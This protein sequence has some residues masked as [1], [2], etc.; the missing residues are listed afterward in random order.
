M[1][2]IS[3]FSFSGDIFLCIDNISWKFK[4][5]Q[6]PI[7]FV[8]FPLFD[9][10]NLN[11][12]VFFFFSGD[13]F[14]ALTTPPPLIRSDGHCGGSVSTDYWLFRHPSWWPLVNT[15][16]EA[17]IF[18]YGAKLIITMIAKRAVCQMFYT[19]KILKSPK[20]APKKV[21]KFMKMRNENF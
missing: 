12:I 14:F 20:C 3:H 5:K 19:N 13:I 2:K 17:G 10:E 8:S 7:C 21:R 6:N 9:E 16:G 4:I 11:I 1:L 18:G 15:S